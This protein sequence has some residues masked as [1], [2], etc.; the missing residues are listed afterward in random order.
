MTLLLH[1]TILSFCVLSPG[2]RGV[3]NRNERQKSAGKKQ[4]WS[5]H[6][7]LHELAPEFYVTKDRI[8]RAFL[9]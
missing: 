6:R 4:M 7:L 5:T 8:H 1:A 3:A 2:N 9:H